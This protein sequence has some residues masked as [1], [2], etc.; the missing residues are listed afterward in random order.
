MM[1]GTSKTAMA[2]INKYTITPAMAGKVIGILIFRNVLSLPT[3]EVY[4]A[5]SNEGS[6]DR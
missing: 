1:A 5:S 6:I 3:P 4:A 2:V